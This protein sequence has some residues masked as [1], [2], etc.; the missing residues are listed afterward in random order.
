MSRE[1]FCESGP[2]HP[3]GGEGGS[4]F[5]PE[6]YRMLEIPIDGVYL[7][8]FMKKHHLDLDEVV[9][10]LA[11]ACH[12][13]LWGF[14]DDALDQLLFVRV[15]PEQ[16]LALQELDLPKAASEKNTPRHAMEALS[17]L[18]QLAVGAGD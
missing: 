14:E 13:E 2:A 4:S 5:L 3:T 16:Y 17:A 15:T 9:L 11:D 7:D 1:Q 18:V 10:R 8:Y 6:G 12:R